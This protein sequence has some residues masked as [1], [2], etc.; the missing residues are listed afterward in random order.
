MP[1]LTQALH[2]A[3]RDLELT[4]EELHAALAFLTEVGRADEFVLLSDVLGLS[5]LVDDLTHA[6]GSGTPSNVLGP[7][8]R[9]GAPWIDNPGSIAPD[10]EPGESLMVQGRVTDA[11]TGRAIGGATLDVWQAD[12]QGVYSGQRGNAPGSWNLRGRQRAADDGRYGFRTVRPLH[13][14]IKD[15]GPVGRLLRILGRH[16]WR[17]AHIH[18]LVTAEGYRTLVTQ[19]YISGGPYLGDDA[20]DGVKDDLVRDIQDGVLLFDLELSPERHTP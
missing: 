15:D 2:T 8:H 9:P 10:G 12:A 6:S 13:Y 17:P 5:R 7:F 14:T 20:I 18:F 19:A 4:N 3:A 11:T 16:P 1:Q